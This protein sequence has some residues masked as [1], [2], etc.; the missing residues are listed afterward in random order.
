[1]IKK[2]T[3]GFFRD[4]V[5]MV[6]NLPRYKR[7]VRVGGIVKDL[8]KV[9]QIPADFM[10]NEDGVIVDLERGGLMGYE[11][12]EAFIPHSEKCT[13]CRKNCISPTCRQEYQLLRYGFLSRI[14]YNL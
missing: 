9:V 5:K 4:A 8:H 1:M 7:Y 14:S 11:R 2:S 13:C 3:P 6:A 12:V 10:I